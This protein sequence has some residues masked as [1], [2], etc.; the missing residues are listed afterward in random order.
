MKVALVVGHKLS[1]PGACAEDGTCEFT[2]NDKL[3]NNVATMLNNINIDVVVVYRTKKFSE[4]P[5]AIN[6]E[7][8][9][10]IVSFHCNAYDT[11]ASGTEVLYY[12]KSITSKAVAYIFQD[13]IVNC[14][15]LP[16]RGIKA[17]SVEERGGFLLRYT[18]APCVLLEPFFIDNNNDYSVVLSK[19][20]E[21]LVSIVKSVK[22]SLSLL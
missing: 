7:N 2:F 14:L 18:N 10:L 21:F 11:K 20:D 8:P 9:D 5:E 12:H 6:A 17:R 19:Y 3:V 22:E 15:E 16:N 4:L 1:S 13:N